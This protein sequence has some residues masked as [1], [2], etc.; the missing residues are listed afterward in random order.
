MGSAGVRPGIR[1]EGGKCSCVNLAEGWRGPPCAAD[2]TAR[3]CTSAR[4]KGGGRAI[5]NRRRASFLARKMAPSGVTIGW[6]RFERNVY[7]DF[8]IFTPF[9]FSRNSFLIWIFKYIYSFFFFFIKTQTFLLHI[10]WTYSLRYLKAYKWIFY[11]V[12]RFHSI[13]IPTLYIYI[14]LTLSIIFEIIF[15]I[16][17]EISLDRER[18]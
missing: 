14:Y 1:K 16:P 13:S 2:L 11:F 6:K 18:R 15:K 3:G 10:R 17:L 12:R 4:S 8:E 5:R 7:S 9:S